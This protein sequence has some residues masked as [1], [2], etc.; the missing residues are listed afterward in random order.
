M[1]GRSAF[2]IYT[3]AGVRT[4]DAS[5]RVNRA[6]RVGRATGGSSPNP[7]GSRLKALKSIKFNLGLTAHAELFTILLESRESCCQRRK[8]KTHIGFKIVVMAEKALL[9]IHLQE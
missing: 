8:V 4:F 5:C 7:S 6:D 2:G 9:E 1:S 3:H